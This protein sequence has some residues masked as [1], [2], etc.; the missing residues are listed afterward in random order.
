MNTA[1]ETR[2]IILCRRVTYLQL[3]ELVDVDLLVLVLALVIQPVLRLTQ[4]LAEVLTVL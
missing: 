4:Q 1:A 3:L 2:N